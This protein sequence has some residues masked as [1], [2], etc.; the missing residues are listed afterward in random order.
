MPIFLECIRFLTRWQRMGNPNLIPNL[1]NHSQLNP[2]T[3]DFIIWLPNVTIIS[4]LG[5]F[6]IVC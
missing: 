6:F 1:Y 4:Q 5:H 3:K 2:M